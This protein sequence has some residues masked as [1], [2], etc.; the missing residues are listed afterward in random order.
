MDDRLLGRGLGWFSIGLGLAE[1]TVTRNLVQFFGM[2]GSAGLVRLFGLREIA[3]GVAIL[4]A[5]DPA[6]FVWG[7][8][9]GDGLDLAALVSGL[10]PGNPKRGRVGVAVAVIAAIT[11]LDAFC[12]Q[13]L[14]EEGK[15]LSAARR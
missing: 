12:A 3:T 2:E 6:L 11:A 8:V 13:R 7:R 1:V 5:S 14:T 15:A 10:G 9:A 4:E